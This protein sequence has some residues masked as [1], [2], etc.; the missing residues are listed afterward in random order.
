M[1][2]WKC[3]AILSMECFQAISLRS[4][5]EQIARTGAEYDERY[6]GS[7]EYD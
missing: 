2:S 6:Q 3:T 4:M 1:I 5:D 7:H